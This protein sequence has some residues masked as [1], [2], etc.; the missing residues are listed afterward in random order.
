MDLSCNR[1][2][3]F[4]FSFYLFVH[5]FFIIKKKVKNS[6]QLAQANLKLN[7]SASAFQ[8]LPYHVQLY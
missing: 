8:D 4:L 3:T 1:T 7:L 2:T 6:C 5:S